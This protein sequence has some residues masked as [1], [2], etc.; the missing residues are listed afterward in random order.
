MGK[1]EQLDAEIAKLLALLNAPD[2]QMLENP[3]DTETK[4]LSDEIPQPEE[5]R[6]AEYVVSLMQKPTPKT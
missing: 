6:F 3:P 4:S 1:P 2:D 5:T